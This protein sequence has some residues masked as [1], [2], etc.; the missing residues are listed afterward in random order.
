MAHVR[1][2]PNG[3]FRIVDENEFAGAARRRHPQ[4]E[5]Q[6]LS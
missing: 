4:I 3:Q 2:E 6:N 5:T 1:R